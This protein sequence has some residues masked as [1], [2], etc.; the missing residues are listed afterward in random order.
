MSSS[1]RLG[2]YRYMDFVRIGL[3]LNLI[4]WIVG[5]AAIAMFFP[6]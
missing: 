3:P 6:F 2:G 5:V 4:T 1:T